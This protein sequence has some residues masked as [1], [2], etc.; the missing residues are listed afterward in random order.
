MGNKWPLGDLKERD[1]ITPNIFSD[2]FWHYIEN[3]LEKCLLSIHLA[4]PPN[5]IEIFMQNLTQI[6][7]SAEQG[8]MGDL[9][10]SHFFFH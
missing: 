10:A 4:I 1:D 5:P 6:M 8:S 2:N 9:K 7:Q 3:V